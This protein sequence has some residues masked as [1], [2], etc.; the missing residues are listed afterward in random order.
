MC[1]HNISHSQDLYCVRIVWFVYQICMLLCS[2]LSTH[3]VTS[4]RSCIT[5]PPTWRDAIIAT[6]TVPLFRAFG[7]NKHSPFRASYCHTIQTQKQM[8]YTSCRCYEKIFCKTCFFICH[9]ICCKSKV[10]IFFAVTRLQTIAYTLR[11]K[12]WPST[13]EYD[14]ENICHFLQ[15]CVIRKIISKLIK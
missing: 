11:K 10:F 3:C 7:G 12:L 13:K 5:S 8:F 9:A 15:Y 6:V 1:S 14:K 2:Y 4:Q